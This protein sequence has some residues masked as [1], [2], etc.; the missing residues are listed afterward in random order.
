MILCRR[1]IP[2]CPMI[3]FRPMTPCYRNYRSQVLCWT[4][5]RL[6]PFQA[7]FQVEFYSNLV[8]VQILQEWPRH[9]LLVRRFDR[10]ALVPSCPT[11]HDLASWLH[12]IRRW[13]RSRFQIHSPLCYLYYPI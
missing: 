13:F 2:Y 9:L 7:E 10:K 8:F 11:I 3:R 12:S 4:R 6:I 1:M 5:F